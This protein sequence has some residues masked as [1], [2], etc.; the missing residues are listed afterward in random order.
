MTPISVMDAAFAQVFAGRKLSRCTKKSD[1]SVF[2][3]IWL[4]TALLFNTVAYLGNVFLPLCMLMMVVQL[5]GCSCPRRLTGSLVGLNCVMF[6]I[7]ASAGRLPIYY[8]EVEFAIVDGNAQLVKVYGPL[9]PFYKVFLLGYFGAMIAVTTV[10]SAKKKA[11]SAKTPTFL[12]MLVLGNIAMWLVEN[13][14]G[15]NFEF[16]SIS[17]LMTEGV[18][19]LLYGILQDHEI[20]LRQTAAAEPPMPEE[21]EPWDGSGFSEAQL[22]AIFTR[23]KAVH[24]LS[25]REREVLRMLLE[26]LKRK[27]IAEALYVT[28]STIKKHTSNIFKKLEASSRSELIAMAAEHLE[29]KQ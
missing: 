29:Q 10:S 14:T 17:Y 20:A 23:W 28:E 25:D 4:K 22:H 6:L 1:I 24:N 15:V 5:S 3:K 11:H 21:P 19:L 9:H 13:L 7:T 18:I 2:E 26:N 8:K 12:A 16:L 27:D